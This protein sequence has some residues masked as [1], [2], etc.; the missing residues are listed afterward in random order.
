[1]FLDVQPFALSLAFVPLASF[2]A[3]SDA[4]QLPHG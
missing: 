4:P 3:E 2:G 1:M